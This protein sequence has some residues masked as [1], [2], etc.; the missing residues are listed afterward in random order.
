MYASLGEV[1]RLIDAFERAAIPRPDWTHAA[2]VTV[3]CWYV[4]H[5]T[6]DE[7]FSHA[8]SRIIRLNEA[9][10]VANTTESGYHNTITGLWLKIIA[11]R[12][13]LTPRDAGAL[14]VVNPVVEYCLN[15]ALPL[16][17]YSR[18]RLF[19]TTARVGWVDPDLAPFPE[20]T[21]FARLA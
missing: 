5:H 2:H 8:R 3:G 12:I 11:H 17:Y 6:Y 18:D 19:S 1:G 16:A 14:D 10:G 4:L 20:P 7:A 21:Q 15:R 13:A 9:N